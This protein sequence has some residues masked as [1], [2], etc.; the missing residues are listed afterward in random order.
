M[1][2]K[3]EARRL[4]KFARRILDNSSLKKLKKIEGE[5]RISAIKY[6]MKARL[7][8]EHDYLKKD[9]KKME[10]AGKEVFF[11]ETKLD[12][13]NSK[14]KLFNAALHKSDF[15]NMANLFKQIQKE[16]EDV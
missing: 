2:D 16:A 9:V 4:M 12:L 5:D 6:A 11:L 1:E 13:L 15:I 3:K 10:K 14:I 8:R 7:E